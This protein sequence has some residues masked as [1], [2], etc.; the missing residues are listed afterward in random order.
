MDSKTP[1]KDN[2]I[3]FWEE[4][5]LTLSGVHPLHKYFKGVMEWN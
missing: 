5:D 2:Y 1:S 4:I 3:M